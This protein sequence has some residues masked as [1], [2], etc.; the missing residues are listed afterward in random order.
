M[1]VTPEQVAAERARVRVANEIASRVPIFTIDV[2]WSPEDT[3]ALR[4]TLAGKGV[5]A[6]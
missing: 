2:L 1:D 4:T 5:A 6:R 3:E